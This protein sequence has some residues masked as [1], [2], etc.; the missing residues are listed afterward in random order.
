MEQ[1]L[2]QANAQ[3]TFAIAVGLRKYFLPN[4]TANTF[5]INLYQDELS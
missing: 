3:K 4:A 2:K 1:T 5:L